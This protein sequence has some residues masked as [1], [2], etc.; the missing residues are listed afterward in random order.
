MK[1]DK[2]FNFGGDFNGIN[3]TPPPPP[4]LSTDPPG[5]SFTSASFFDVPY[6][7]QSKAQELDIYLPARGTKPYPVIVWF[8]GGGFLIGDKREGIAPHAEPMLAGG[9]AVVSINYR[10]SSEAIF[11]AQ[12]YDAK[13][14]IRWIGANAEKYNFNPGKIVA[15]GSSAGGYLA[16]LLGTSAHVKE[17]EDLSMGNPE[18]SS[19]VNAVVDWFGPIDFLQLNVQ[20]AQLGQKA[21]HNDED[22]FESKLIGGQP[23]KF[24]EKCRAANPMSYIRADNPPFYIQHGLID[25][26]VPYLQSVNLAEALKAVIGQDKVRLELIEN[27]GHMDPIHHSPEN[28]KKVLD[29]LGENLM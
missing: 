15:T 12:I 5:Q 10:F 8:H 1:N 14:A 27:A 16:A 19:R 3:W 2:S 26:M 29:F 11:P 20:H 24:P 21:Q 18:Q 13:A 22:S 6:A 4:N 23:A 17:L 28:I 9:Y 7:T 25:D